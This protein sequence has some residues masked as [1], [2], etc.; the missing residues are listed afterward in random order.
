MGAMPASAA[1]PEHQ[2]PEE[3]RLRAQLYRLLAFVLARPPGQDGLSVLS[4]LSGDSTDLGQALGTL[5]RVAGATSPHQAEREF[6]DLFIGV[7]R[8]EFK[9]LLACG[10]IKQVRRA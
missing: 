4:G 6:H 5:G 2:V 8:G 7:G 9:E 3:D 1:N 10:H